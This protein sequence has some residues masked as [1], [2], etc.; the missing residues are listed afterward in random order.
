METISSDV[1][2]MLPM[3]RL[4][5]QL[6]SLELSCSVYRDIFERTGLNNPS[7]YFLNK[8]TYVNLRWIGIFGQFLTI[9]IVELTTMR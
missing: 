7:N 9:N 1:T 5:T 6:I 8:S 4:S 3:L 2:T